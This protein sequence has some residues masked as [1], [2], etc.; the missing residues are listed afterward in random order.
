MVCLSPIALEIWIGVRRSAPYGQRSITA[1]PGNLFHCSLWNVKT[2]F[3][4]NLKMF[5]DDSKRS[6]HCPS[7]RLLL[8]MQNI[9]VDVGECE[10]VETLGMC[11]LLEKETT[12]KCTAQ[13]IFDCIIFNIQWK[14]MQVV[15]RDSVQ[16]FFNSVTRKVALPY[17]ISLV[18][19]FSAAYLCN[20]G[21]VSQ[22][23]FGGN[24][25]G[26]TAT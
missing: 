16:A 6:H 20:H 22:T 4:E 24:V 3:P 21:K 14:A 11:S 18:S 10:K 15:C 23:T 5:C 17:F 13:N 7:D 25:E 2:L 1:W 12:R 26:V 9:S 8:S 19:P